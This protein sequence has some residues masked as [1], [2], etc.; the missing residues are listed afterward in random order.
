MCPLPHPKQEQKND[1]V[2]ATDSQAKKDENSLIIKSM[3]SVHNPLRSMQNNTQIKYGKQGTPPKYKRQVAENP[4]TE[5]WTTQGQ[6]KCPHP[7][8]WKRVR[9]H[10]VPQR[11]GQQHASTRYLPTAHSPV[12][13]RVTRILK[14]GRHATTG[15][16]PLD[17]WVA[18]EMIL[19]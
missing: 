7:N 1:T 15:S 3:V 12:M 5:L 17:G 16:K 6:N 13:Q 4:Q 2:T 18:V 14:A 11:S 10:K 9:S 8:T 19:T